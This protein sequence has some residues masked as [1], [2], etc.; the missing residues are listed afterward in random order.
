MNSH[1]GSEF[2]LFTARV[3]DKYA[4]QHSRRGFLGKVFSGILKL[5]GIS[6]IPALP[7]IRIVTVE[8]QGVSCNDWRL[9]GIWGYLCNT[10][11]CGATGGFSTCPGCTQVG[12]YWECCCA[13]P[14]GCPGDGTRFR[15][16]DCCGYNDPA[17]DC[18]GAACTRHPGGAQPAWCSSGLPYQCTI[19][20]QVASCNPVPGAC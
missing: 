3:L 17:A 5:L 10:T 2:D 12:S 4:Q 14:Y 18:R 7:L 1:E 8:A 15:Y 20:E 19:V 11:C 9:C 16:K 6:L 13:Y